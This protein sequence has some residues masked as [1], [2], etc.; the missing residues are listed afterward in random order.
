MKGRTW[1]QNFNH[2]QKTRFFIRAEKKKPYPSLE[3]NLGRP[4]SFRSKGYGC[5]LPQCVPVWWGCPAIRWV[6]RAGSREWA[7]KL[8][9]VDKPMIIGPRRNV[10]GRP[11]WRQQLLLCRWRGQWFGVVLFQNHITSFRDVVL[12]LF[13]WFLCNPR[14]KKKE[15]VFLFFPCF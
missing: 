9:F 15:K 5:P 2:F 6:I 14:K 3:F 4:F 11:I 10:A 1:I 7:G 12:P 13:G 8:G